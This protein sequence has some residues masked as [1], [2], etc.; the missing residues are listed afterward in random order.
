M[1]TYHESQ[2]LRATWLWVA[3]IF[4]FTVL[5]WSGWEEGRLLSTL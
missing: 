3:A 5:L 2:P 1:D 4:T